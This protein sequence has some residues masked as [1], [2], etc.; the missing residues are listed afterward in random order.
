MLARCMSILFGEI[1]CAP[2][3]VARWIS[4]L[5]AQGKRSQIMDYKIVELPAFAS[6]NVAHIVRF[7]FPC[8]VGRCGLHR[9]GPHEC[10]LQGGLLRGLFR[11]A[12]VR[13]AL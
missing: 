5:G 12:P 2:N 8:G 3:G 6:L 4:M 10:G 1:G 9:F 11:A 7:G 13:Q